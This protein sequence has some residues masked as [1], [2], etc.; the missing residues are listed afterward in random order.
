MAYTTHAV[1]KV[2]NTHL[3]QQVRFFVASQDTLWNF[4]APYS[5]PMAVPQAS[6]AVGI[7]GVHK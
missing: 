7:D 6:I 1:R 2:S 3:L 4:L 5:N